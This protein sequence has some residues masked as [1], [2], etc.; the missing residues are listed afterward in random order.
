MSSLRRKPN[1]RFW[2]A[3]FTGPD[4]GQ[5]QRSTKVPIDGATPRQMP[6]LLQDI[7]SL[8][9]AEVRPKMP[10]GTAARL[11]KRDARRLAEL[12]AG[13]FEVLAIEARSGR[14]TE[15][16]ARR[17]V[18][19]IYEKTNREA[20]PSSSVRDFMTGW[21]ERKGIEVGE[22]TRDRYAVAIDSFL[23]HLGNRAQVDLAHLRSRDIANWRDAIAGKVTPSTVNFGIKV[24]RAALHSARRDGLVSENEAGKVTI[25]KTHANDTRRPFTPAELRR[26]LAAADHEWRGMILVGLYTG[27]RLGDVARL[28]WGDTDLIKRCVTFTAAKTNRRMEI[29]MA[30]P[31]HRYIEALPAPDDPHAYLFPRAA[32]CYERNYFNGLL[33][34]QFRAILVKVGLAEARKN[35]ET[36]T[37]HRGVKHKAEELSFHSLRHTFVS[38]LKDAGATDSVARDLAGHESADVNR[39]YTHLAPATR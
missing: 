7:A 4:G 3:C 17:T 20:L 23:D 8:L 5:V 31:L 19:D 33:S 13:R 39:L 32:E 29:P 28:R 12:I 10:T 9:E 34:K 22:K 21:L 38:W 26:T 27:A 35:R 14:L 16:A 1:S 30:A 18:A 25:L 24:I 2:I 37:G 6:R 36:G 15:A 11:N